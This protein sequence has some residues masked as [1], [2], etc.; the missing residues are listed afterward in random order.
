[1]EKQL[2]EYGIAEI[3]AGYAQEGAGFVCTLCGKEYEAGRVYE[4]DGG[5]L[6]DAEGAAK[7]H[8]AQMHGT[9]ADWLLEQDAALL[10]LTEVQRQLL[11]HVAAGKQDAEIAK[12]C[13][14]APSTVRNHR[15]KLREKEKQATLYLALLRSLAEK[16]KQGI[17]MTGQGEFDAVH[18]AATMVDDRYGITAAEREKTIKTYFDENGALRQI[19]AREKKKIIVLREIMRSFKPEETYSE[20]EINRVLGRI[21]PDYATLRRALIEYGFMDRTPDGSVYRAAGN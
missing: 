4:L 3:A 10:G 17:G 8:V 5:L 11:R 14:V 2:W 21:H 9:A 15:F 6:Y 16:T 1:M 13:G 19:P 7:R 20:K 12:L 18:A